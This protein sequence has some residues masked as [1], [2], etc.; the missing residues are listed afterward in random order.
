MPS[1]TCTVCGTKVELPKKKDGKGST[2]VKCPSCGAKAPL[3][4]KLRNGNVAGL[5][6]CFVGISRF[7]KRR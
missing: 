3:R 5:K 6:G 2:E 1:R 4:I 7:V